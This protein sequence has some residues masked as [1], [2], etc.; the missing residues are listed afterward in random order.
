LLD[1]FVTD[2]CGEGIWKENIVSISTRP[3]TLPNWTEETHKKYQTLFDYKTCGN[4]QQKML[5]KCQMANSLD[6]SR[7]EV[8]QGSQKASSSPNGMSSIKVARSAGDLF[9]RQCSSRAADILC[10]FVVTYK[11]SL[12]CQVENRE[13]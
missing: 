6:V 3:I 9:Q 5:I 2:G 4:M 12:M 1:Y 10:T 13:I 11:S 8:L 7:S